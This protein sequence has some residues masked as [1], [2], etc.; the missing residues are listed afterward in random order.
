[1][2]HKLKDMLKFFDESLTEKENM[3]INGFFEIYDSG[4]YKYILKNYK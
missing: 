1:M 4:N 3:H 2:K